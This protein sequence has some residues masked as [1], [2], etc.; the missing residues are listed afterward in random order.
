MLGIFVLSVVCVGLYIAFLIPHSIT[1]EMI[2]QGNLKTEK[3]INYPLS[4]R[5]YFLESL[6]IL[7]IINIPNMIIL[8]GKFKKS[9]RTQI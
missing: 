2:V 5:T 4:F 1:T 9:L 8:F 6:K 7:C 3:V